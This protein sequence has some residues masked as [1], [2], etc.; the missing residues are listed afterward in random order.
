MEIKMAEYTF[1]WK[2]VIYE[3]ETG[4]LQEAVRCAFARL[5]GLSCTVR[6]KEIVFTDYVISPPDD[7]MLD[8]H[9]IDYEGKLGP[10]QTIPRTVDRKG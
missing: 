5:P 6:K 2:T 3:H 8:I 7:K 1:I 9:V 4:D 10:C